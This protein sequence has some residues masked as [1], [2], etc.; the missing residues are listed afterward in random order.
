MTTVQFVPKELAP[1]SPELPKA[2]I[3]KI[4]IKRSQPSAAPAGEGFSGSVATGM[5]ETTS[6]ALSFDELFN[7]LEVRLNH[8]NQN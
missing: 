4:K 6:T 2:A 1:A 3:F 7:H 8:R 5:P